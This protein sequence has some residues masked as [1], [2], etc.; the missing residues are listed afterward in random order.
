MKATAPFIQGSLL[1][2]CPQSIFQIAWSTHA[3]L[4]LSSFNESYPN[5]VEILTCHNDHYVHHSL[6]ETIYPPSKIMWRNNEEDG[7]GMVTD[8]FR[9]Y[10][11]SATTTI[12]TCVL[13]RSHPLTSFDWCSH[14]CVV[15]SSIDTTVAVWNLEL[16]QRE[17]QWQNPTQEV[18]DIACQH[19]YDIATVDK[20]GIARWWDRRQPK[21]STVLYE[22][23]NQI[24]LIRIGWNPQ[25]PSLVAL[26]GLDLKKVILVDNRYPCG[27]WLELQAHS[28]V[29]NGFAWSPY[30]ASQLITVGEDAYVFLWDVSSPKCIE[31]EP[32]SV[33]VAEEAIHQNNIY[34]LRLP[35]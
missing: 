6:I 17:I 28:G 8:M 3:D 21:A 2:K 16:Q 12:E 33:Y 5:T 9:L 4:A 34:R 15:L 26:L 11:M 30:H 14:N 23:K 22:T 31:P 35:P 13:P 32:S 20:E 18:Y 19:E 27:S 1:R 24:P 29:I 10:T 25:Y 7:L